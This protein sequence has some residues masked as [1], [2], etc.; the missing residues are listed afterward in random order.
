[1][2]QSRSSWQIKGLS[3]AAELISLIDLTSH[4]RALLSSLQGKA[5]AVAPKMTEAFYARL[6]AHSNTAEYLE[7]APMDH[8]HA[9]VG[10]WFCDL[11]SG[12]Y[13]EEYAKKRI[14]IGQTHVKVGLPVR[15]P[16]AML[17]VI[18]PFGEELARQS[19]QPE[20]AVTAFRKVL[21]IDVAIFNQAYEENQLA[22]LAEFVGGERLAR[23]LI[24]GQ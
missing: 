21:S 7:G 1:M 11:F 15:Y 8:L 18:M 17:D 10:N 24:S 3:T 4:E 12:Q 20:Q 14:A 16:L 9:M 5:K 19:N 13:D 2:S 22:H 23:L 6:F